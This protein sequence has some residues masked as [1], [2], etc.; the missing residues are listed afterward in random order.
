MQDLWQTLLDVHYTFL[1]I[2]EIVRVLKQHVVLQSDANVPLPS[3]EVVAAHEQ[4]LDTLSAEYT[5]SSASNPGDW[6][7]RIVTNILSSSE[8]VDTVWKPVKYHV[9]RTGIGDGSKDEALA[10][11]MLITDLLQVDLMFSLGV[12]QIANFTR[13]MRERE[14]RK[15]LSSNNRPSSID[16]LFNTPRGAPLLN[17]A[18]MNTL[19]S[20]LAEV[21]EMNGCFQP[22]A[23]VNDLKADYDSEKA[24]P[25]RH[26]GKTVNDTWL[27]FPDVSPNRYMEAH[28]LL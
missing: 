16:L 24:K 8:T 17:S 7:S 23:R 4:R 25:R 9:C 3:A 12:R 22:E 15:K 28:G 13:E 2:C 11:K 1:H 26:L 21:D 14:L 6:F 5:R 10:E 18:P 27:V 19:R 20:M